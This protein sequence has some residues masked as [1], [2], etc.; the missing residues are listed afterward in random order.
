[1]EE[2]TYRRLHHLRVPAGVT[3]HKYI[4][5]A[6]TDKLHD[7]KDSMCPKS[8]GDM[9]TPKCVFTRLAIMYNL[10]NAKGVDKPGKQSPKDAQSGWGNGV[11]N[12]LLQVL[13]GQRFREDGSFLPPVTVRPGEYEAK[14]LGSI[15]WRSLDMHPDAEK[16]KEYILSDTP[17]PDSY[18]QI[19]KDIAKADLTGG[20]LPGALAG[21]VNRV[22]RESGA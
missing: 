4:T 16:I 20:P 13:G 19:L 22:W 11:Y 15:F 6:M 2:E 18:K 1:M 21:E 10:L 7:Y 17:E 3:R 12:G 8:S 9:M 5:K 14:Y